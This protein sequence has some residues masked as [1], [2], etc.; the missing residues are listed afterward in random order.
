MLA[1]LLAALLAASLVQVFR[2]LGPGLVRSTV[3]NG[4][5]MVVF[6]RT[7]AALEEKLGKGRGSTF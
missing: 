4:V 2:G 6:T 1:A 3:A 5:G 7:R